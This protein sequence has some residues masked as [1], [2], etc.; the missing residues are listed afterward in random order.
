MSWRQ[1][2]EQKKVE[3]ELEEEVEEGVVEEEEKEEEEEVEYETLMWM[4]GRGREQE[5]Y[6]PP[7][8]PPSRT[9]HT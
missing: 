4:G 3:E 7:P 6:R 9:I 5:M 2:E 8:Y 1:K